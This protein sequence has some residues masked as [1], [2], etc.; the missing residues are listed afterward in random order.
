MKTT[1]QIELAIQ[2][3]LVAFAEK[4]RIG[5]ISIPAATHSIRVGLSL[6]ARGYPMEVCLG[7]FFH[8]LL[9]DTLFGASYIMNLFGARVDYLMRACTLDPKLGDTPEGEQELFDRVEGMAKA[10]DLDPLRIKC[11]D[12]LDNLRTNN[13]LKREWQ[14][15]AVEKGKRWV[16]AAGR[17]FPTESLTHELNDM[18]ARE[19]KRILA[20]VTV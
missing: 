13:C 12:S 6:L 7:G 10:G 19:E 4:I 18:V 2:I 17:Y 14:L 8:D 9:E 20:L 11:E 15:S 16:N 3:V 1:R 5:K